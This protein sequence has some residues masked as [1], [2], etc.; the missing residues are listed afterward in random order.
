ML[1]VGVVGA[2]YWGPKVVRSLL[3]LPECGLVRA[4]DTRPG[5]L[6][7]LAE[8]FPQVELTADYD[9]LLS[10]GRLDAIFIVT[11][12]GSHHALALRALGSGRHVFVEKPFAASTVE[13]R[14]LTERAAAA[15]LVLAVGH[16]FVFHPGIMCLHAELEAGA[17]GRLCYM[18]SGRVNLGPPA[19]EVD[20]LWDLAVHDVAI[21]L[22][23]SRSAPVEVTA[24]AGRYVH[25]TL[26]DMALLVIRYADGSL[27]H[28]H[29]S[30]LSPNKVR[31]FFVAGAAG[32]A[33]FDGCLE[34]RALSLFGRGY[35]SRI[36]LRDDQAI[37]LQY[38]A[39]EV[40]VPELP[41]VEPLK[42]ECRHFL[43]C[44]ATGSRPRA[45]GP[46][47]LQSIEILEAAEQSIAQG[48]KP[49]AL[50]ASA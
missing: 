19:S 36:G 39:G 8:Q 16:L 47:G 30:W 20:V 2:G 6:Q 48:A 21:A 24:Y 44:I 1:G 46:E 18:E 38:S 40:R 13:A 28:H 17:L 27:S 29:V 26:L 42:D 32:S 22:Y 43:E 7:H 3:A 37:A 9:E 14:D 49:V 31:R 45:G 12:V 41:A 10:D 5:R 34:P 35:D 15:R 25:P 4:C 23:L 50:R 11:P 33:L